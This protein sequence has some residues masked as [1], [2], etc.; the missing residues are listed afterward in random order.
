LR[1]LASTRGAFANKI[2]EYLLVY[3]EIQTLNSRALKIDVNAVAHFY[4]N[5]ESIGVFKILASL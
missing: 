3:M 4:P 2:P 5:T 1:G